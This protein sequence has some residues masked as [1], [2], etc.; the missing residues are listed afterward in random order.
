MLEAV[1]EWIDQVIFITIKFVK[2]MH[3]VISFA[4]IM[5]GES[6]IQ[7]MHWNKEVERLSNLVSQLEE[8]EQYGTSKFL[9]KNPLQ[10]MDA[11]LI[12]VLRKNIA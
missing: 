8:V 6:R 10:L 3:R 5:L 11:S 9:E 7:M 1:G 4:E 12:Y 2:E